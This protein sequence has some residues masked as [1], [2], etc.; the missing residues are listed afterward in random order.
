MSPGSVRP[1]ASG[2]PGGPH[3]FRRTTAALLV[4]ALAILLV[5][6][7]D[8]DSSADKTTTTAPDGKQACDPA[9][10]PTKDPGALKVATGD[11]AFSPWVEDDKPESGKGFESAVVY[12]VAD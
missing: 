2:T 6:C 7:G 4:A 3:M 12:A 11:P 1:L 9:S 5:S 10:L 8:D